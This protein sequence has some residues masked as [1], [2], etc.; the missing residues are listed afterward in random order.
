MNNMNHVQSCTIIT[1][2]TITNLKILQSNQ[3]IKSRLETNKL[4]WEWKLNNCRH[5]T[6]VSD[7]IVKANH[8]LNP[9]IFIIH[10]TK[11]HFC[12]TNLI[13]HSPPSPSSP[14]NSSLLSHTNFI[15]HSISNYSFKNRIHPVNQN[16]RGSPF[17]HR[18]FPSS[19]SKEF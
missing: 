5:Y 8:S 7:I 4:Y 19:T 17:L 3:T 12:N 13:F 6:F 9:F 10:S 1:I 16:N 15:Y 2:I 18:K 11:Y 14:T